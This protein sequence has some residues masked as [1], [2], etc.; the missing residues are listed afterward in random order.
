[1]SKLATVF[2]LS[3][4][5]LFAVMCV[6]LLMLSL[7]RAGWKALSVQTGSMRPAIKPKTLVLVH[8][9]P[10]NQLKVGDVITYINPA[11]KRSTITHRIIYIQGRHII[12][13]GDAN[14]IADAPLTSAVVVGKVSYAVPHAGYA[15]DFIQKPLG[16]AALLILAIY[17]PT[18]VIILGA[19]RRLNEYYRKTKPYVAAQAIDRLGQIENPLRAKVFMVGKLTIIL[20]VASV[21]IV[22]PVQALLM[23]KATLQGNTIS[24]GFPITGPHVTFR[25]V[26]LRCSS[27]NTV[28]ASK[29]PRIVIQNWTSQTITTHHWHIDDNSGVIT[30]IPNGTV[31]KKL[32]QYVFTPLLANGLQYAG[33]NLTVFNDNNQAVDALSWGTDTSAFNPNILATASGSRLERRPFNK[34]TDKASDWRLTN[35]TC[36]CPLQPDVQAGDDTGDLGDQNEPNRVTTIGAFNLQ[37][38]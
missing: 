20:V 21:F 2:K 38:L 26:T 11:N 13:K 8:R 28:S 1:M 7:P 14:P 4:T 23:S 35:H 29:R 30:T 36:H 16:L 6:A 18:L 22:L 32:H 34:D 33:D 3:S 27:D 10:V 5:A 19:I 37:E 31:L 17:I 24:A 15:T 12:V 25:L 9:V